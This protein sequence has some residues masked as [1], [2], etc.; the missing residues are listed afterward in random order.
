M[1]RKPSRF[2]C[3][4]GLGG[5]QETLPNKGGH[6]PSPCGQGA[7]LWAPDEALRAG[8]LLGEVQNRVSGRPTAGRNGYTGN[9]TVSPAGR[10]PHEMGT[11]EL[12]PFWGFGL[13]WRPQRPFQTKEG[14]APH[15]ANGGANFRGP[16]LPCELDLC[17]G[18]LKIGSPAGRRPDGED[19]PEIV[20]FWVFG[21]P[22]MPRET[23]PNKGG[24]RPSP[25]GRGCELPGPNGALQAGTWGKL[26]TGWTR[27]AERA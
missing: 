26:K 1:H 14:L 22:G 10:R 27:L 4:G 3:L 25:C 17:W 11:L 23:L 24:P 16:R 19:T 15:L 18:R 2:G 21:R 8:S 7:N 5:P 20:P 12:L 6:R 9:R 13:P